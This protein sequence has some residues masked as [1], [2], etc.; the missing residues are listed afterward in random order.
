MVKKEK[1]LT[2]VKVDKEMFH[3]FRIECLKNKFSLQKLVERGVY[4][5][6]ND[7][8]FKRM[9]TKVKIDL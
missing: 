2:S 7:P 8:D 4:L 9:L 5:Y 3:T 1:Q 6:L